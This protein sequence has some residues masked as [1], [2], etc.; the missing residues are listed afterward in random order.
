MTVCHQKTAKRNL[1]KKAMNATVTTKLKAPKAAV[2]LNGH[3]PGEVDHLM[4]IW[5]A[6]I[7]SETGVLRPDRR[8]CLKFDK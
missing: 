7:E 1:S 2:L 4:I 5:L 3:C 8:L 6:S